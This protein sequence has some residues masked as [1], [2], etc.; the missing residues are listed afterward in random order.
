M[1][2]TYQSSNESKT[3]EEL[4]YTMSQYKTR[5]EE[6]KVE[7]EFLQLLLSLSIYKPNVLNLFETIEQIKWQ[8]RNHKKETLKLMDKI[9]S[10]TKQID[11]KIE[12]EDLV[13]DNFFI[14]AYNHLEQTLNNHFS[15]LRSFKIKMFEYLACVIKDA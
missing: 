1:E 4:K 15:E 7:S 9:D 8:L 3:V 12:C 6:F 10:Q 2:N 13:C 11:Q 5:L 14:E